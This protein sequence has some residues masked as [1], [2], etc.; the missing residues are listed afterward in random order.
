MEDGGRRY[1]AVSGSNNSLGRVVVVGH[2]VFT[3]NKGMSPG[4]GLHIPSLS[5]IHSPERRGGLEIDCKTQ[6]P[7]REREK[8]GNGPYL[9]TSLSATPFPLT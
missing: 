6:N 9:A 8:G 2:T 5:F 1:T 4:P 3:E 7:E